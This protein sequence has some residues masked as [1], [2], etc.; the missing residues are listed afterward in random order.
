MWWSAVAGTENGVLAAHNAL[1][2]HCCWMLIAK[3]T[4]A[5]RMNYTYTH[6]ILEAKT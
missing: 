5:Q 2:K 4:H 6:K 3:C 1:L